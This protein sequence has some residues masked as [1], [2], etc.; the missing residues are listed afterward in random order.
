MEREAN[1]VAVG[2][3]VLLMVVMGVLFV[4]WY[5]DSRDHRNYQRYEI[6]FDGTVSGLSEGGP[7]RYLGVDVGRVQRIRIDPRA[8]NRV[9]VVAQIDATT[10]ISDQTLAQLSLQGVTGLLYIDLEQEQ[11]SDRG[12]RILAMV[13]SENYPVIRSAHSDLDQFL[14]SLPNLT[15]RLN[16]LVDRASRMLSDGNIQSVGRIVG[17]LDQ[18][19]AGFPRTAR[20][21]NTLVDTLNE[22]T[23]DARRLINDLHASTQTASVDFLAAMQKFRATSDNLLSTSHT[24]DLVASQNRDQINSFVSQGLPQVEALLRDSRAAA[25]QI[26]ELSRGLRENPSRLF[27]QPVANGV[28]IPP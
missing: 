23:Q 21:I 14:S 11:D 7:V 4:Y 15:A 25:Q 17:N 6:Y 9:Q 22:D 1:Y 24:L 28:T 5:S 8:A 16:D 10:P 2:I 20:N 18:A 13:P 26:S 27:Y 3:F 19:S 12:R